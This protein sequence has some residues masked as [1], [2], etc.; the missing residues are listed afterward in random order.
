MHM[1]KHLCKFY[2]PFHIENK[3]NTNRPKKKEVEPKINV[4]INNVASVKIINHC[5]KC[6]T[7]CFH[8][9]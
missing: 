5:V 4:L 2:K 7:T 8:T 3:V 1:K 6:C 9:A